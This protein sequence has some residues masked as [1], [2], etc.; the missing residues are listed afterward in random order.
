[1]AR[2]RTG[3]VDPCR[4]RWRARV[5]GEY[6]GLYDTE[7][8]AWER[9]EAALR[10]DADR[11]PE[12]LR[13]IGATWLDLREVEH[14][15]RGIRSERSVWASRVAAAPFFDWP[16][17]RVKP[18]DVQAW[19]AKL[20]KTEA[21]YTL[22]RKDGPERLA[23]G[24]KLSRTSV[25]HAWRLVKLCMDYAVIEGKLATNPARAVKMP[26]AKAPPRKDGELVI[27]LTEAEI[28]RLLALDLPALERAVFTVAIYAGLR[29]GELW[30]LRWEDVVLDGDRPRLRVRRSYAGPPKS[31]SSL[32]D[33]P[34]L[35]PAAAALRAYHR[36]LTPR[37]IAGLVWPADTGS[38]HHVG[39]DCAWADH[40]ERRGGE[41]HVRKG[42]RTKASIRREVTF[43]CLR[44][45]CG[46]HLVQGTW[47]ARKLTL[48]EA[49]EWLGHSSITVTE[50]HYA[51]PGDLHAAATPKLERKRNAKSDGEGK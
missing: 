25:T 47:T 15:V 26:R 8:E 49:K 7:P 45:T 35:P 18:R 27:Y 44:H 10:I 31:E 37:P 28:A 30:G 41:L 16:I 11:A 23:T 22:Q 48:H 6:L 1:M 17:R 32:R 34:L 36:T 3:T 14:G 9:V 42:W 13:S 33:V 40:R 51:D 19:L 39:Y 4:G 38:C 2:K 20:L 21:R 50:R 5:G 43:H 46:S 24:R 12:S 29:E